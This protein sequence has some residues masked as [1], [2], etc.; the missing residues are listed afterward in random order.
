MKAL[1]VFILISLNLSA[2]DSW[3]FTRDKK[4]HFLAGGGVAMITYSPI[5]F[6]DLENPNPL[7]GLLYSV[8]IG[9]G[10]NLAKELYDLTGLGHASIQDVVYGTTG[11]VVGGLTVFGITNGVLAIRK[12][13]KK[14]K[15]Q[16]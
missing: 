14:K 4:M 9:T 16:L 3:R 10:V 2:Q 1:I 7:R 11:A 12:H 8:Y 5:A 13:I 6:Q 15:I